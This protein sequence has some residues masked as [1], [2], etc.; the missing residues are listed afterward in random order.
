MTF[1]ETL[2]YFNV[3]KRYGDKAQACCPA[4]DDAH[5]SLTITRGRKN[6]LLHCHA[7]C[8]F[9][10]I[11]Q[12]VGLKKSD[13]FYEERPLG[14]SWKAYVEGK[15]GWKVEAVYNYVSL[16]GD[17]AFTKVR[18]QG[19]KMIYGALANERF[20]YGLGGRKRKELCAVYA[21]GGVQAINKAIAEGKPIFIPEGGKDVNGR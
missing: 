12:A 21:P 10:D 1:E 17:Y 16:N 8:R 20:T 14:R 13:L 2:T 9:E 3:R 5:A 4:H 18:L 6:T 19:K 7:G 15:E 11:L